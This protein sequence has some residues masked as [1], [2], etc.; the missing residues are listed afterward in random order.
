MAVGIVV[1]VG[2]WACA[3]SIAARAFVYGSSI[4]SDLSGLD[5]IGLDWT[6]CDCGMVVWLSGCLQSVVVWLVVVDGPM[7]VRD[8]SQPYRHLLHCSQSIEYRV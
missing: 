8:L 2:S 3:A 6:G 7:Y 4:F 1:C 5:W